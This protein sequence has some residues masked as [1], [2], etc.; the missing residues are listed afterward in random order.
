MFFTAGAFLLLFILYVKNVNRLSSKYLCGLLLRG[1]ALISNLFLAVG[2]EGAY[3]IKRQSYPTF[4][5]M[6]DISLINIFERVEVVIGVVWIFGILVK[7]VICFLAVLKGLQHI[8]KHA[9]YRPFLLPCGILVWAMSNHL[10]SNTM[11]FTD[12]V[13]QNWTL[14][15]FSLYVILC[16]LLG[17]GI[18]RRKDKNIIPEQ[19]DQKSI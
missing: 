11:E 6:R 12:F 17:I 3:M 5:V 8:S 10:H 16:T 9:S 15:W 1:F 2:I 19:S 13:G 7:I 18:L 14:W 4:E